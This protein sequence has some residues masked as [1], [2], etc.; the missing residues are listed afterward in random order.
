MDCNEKSAP[1]IL[2]T[3][4]HIGGGSVRTLSELISVPPLFRYRAGSV[5]TTGI[6]SHRGCEINATI[7]GIQIRWDT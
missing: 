3:I 6:A 4:G 2:S 7:L 1:F 5:Q